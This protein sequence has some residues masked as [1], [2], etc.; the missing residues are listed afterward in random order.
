[1]L[2]NVLENS[3]KKY[4]LN[5]KEQNFAPFFEGR[6]LPWTFLNP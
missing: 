5:K 6:Y 3:E 1:M 4:K 2:I